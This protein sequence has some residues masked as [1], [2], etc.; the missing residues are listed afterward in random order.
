MSERPDPAE[1]ARAVGEP[2]ERIA[3]V[4]LRL[5]RDPVSGRV[6][7]RSSVDVALRA[8]LFAELALD[9][10]IVDRAGSP[11]AFPAEPSGDRK[12]DAVR[13]AVEQRP[14]VA[15][16]RWFRHVS[17]DHDALCKELVADG[18]WIR[19]DG[20]RAA[21]ADTEADAVLVLA[22]EIERVVRYERA[23]VDTREAVLAALAV[24][25][26]AT[27]R[28]PR[29][30]A[31]KQ[32][33]AQMVGSVSGKATEATEATETVQKII[34]TAATATRR[35]RRGGSLSHEGVMRR[36]GLLRR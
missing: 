28:W 1:P 12:L 30:S 2:V 15:W 7:H 23:P 34:T 8:A 18:R 6:R 29:P 25:C 21:Y 11:A 35:T 27:G 26:G 5:A 20:W 4:L 13:E 32:D 24:A 19:Q 9:G 16:L 36:G 3:T 14:G 17:S 22:N 10:R 33:L 31:V